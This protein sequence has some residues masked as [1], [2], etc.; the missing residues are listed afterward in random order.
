MA[1][2]YEGEVRMIGVLNFPIWDMIFFVMFIII[3]VIFTAIVCTCILTL[4]K[5]LWGYFLKKRNKNI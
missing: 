2:N 3:I 4:L 1:E 5:F